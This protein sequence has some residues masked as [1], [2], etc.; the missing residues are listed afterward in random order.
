[1]K[2]RVVLSCFLFGVFVLLPGCYEFESIQIPNSI[3]PGSSFNIDITVAVEFFGVNE[4]TGP[5]TQSCYNIL[6]PSEWQTT[7]SI[8]YYGALNGAYYYSPSL[9]D[10]MEQKDGAP[11]GYTWW[12]F[13]SS[14]TVDSLIGTVSFSQ[15]ILTSL[16][17]G[18]YFIDYRLSHASD[19]NFFVEQNNNPIWV[20]TDSSPIDADV[21]VSV[22][23]SD[24][25]SGLSSSD[26]L[27]TISAALLRVSA[28]SMNPRKILIAEGEYKSSGNGEHYPLTIPSYI[29]LIGD[30]LGEVILH[31]EETTLVIMLDSV[32]ADTIRNVTISGGA[33]CEYYDAGIPRSRYGGGGIYS[34]YSE[35][36]LEDVIIRENTDNQGGGV[37]SNVSSIA[38]KNVQILNNFADQGGG[39]YGRSD[40]LNLTNVLIANNSANHGGSGIH[41]VA[42]ASIFL[43]HVTVVNN[44]NIDQ[45]VVYNPGGISIRSEGTIA[46]ITNSILRDNHPH[47][48]NTQATVDISFS[49]VPQGADQVMGEGIVNWLVGNIDADPLFCNPWETDFHLA[50]NSP[51]ASIGEGG[52][53]MG[54]YGVGCFSPSAFSD[55]H[56]VQI[57]EYRLHQNYPNPFNPTTTINYDLPEQS[58]VKLTVFNVQG[59]EVNTLE[60][61][62]KPPGNYE[63]QWNG[64]DQSGNPVSTGVYLC[65]LQA[66]DYSQTIKMVYLR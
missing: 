56:L 58:I 32:R 47:Q 57:L 11:P 6:L 19:P 9:S 25:N 22:E 62:D 36:Y 33:C 3:E 26:P 46:T 35:V 50:E 13:I 23:G 51:A 41:S 40:T 5:P 29:S 45:Y 49:N 15:T 24:E 59:Q 39:I 43:N 61:S 12:S 60:Q 65:R 1:M 27:K 18:L 42:S 37:S 7:D 38:M 28:D 53:D 21:Y 52:S 30:T 8:D 10:S 17:P 64:V 44:S 48:L 66:G 34:E 2:S 31:A 16:E 54:A 55:D 20:G 4:V 14:D 63:V